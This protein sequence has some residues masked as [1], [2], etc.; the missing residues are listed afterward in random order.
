MTN[1][2][3]GAG[4]GGRRCDCRCGVAAVRGC[5]AAETLSV[6]GV[7]GIIGPVV[8]PEDTVYAPKYTLA[9]WKKVRVGMSHS[10]VDTILGPAQRTSWVNAGPDDADTGA[11]WSYS[12]GDTNFRRRL[13]LFRKGIVVEKYSEYYFD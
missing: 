7:A 10:E 1:A 4:R 5:F 3:E 13:L 8:A 9:G 6:D 2:E 12:P 11:E